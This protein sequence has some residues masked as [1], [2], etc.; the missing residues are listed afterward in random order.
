MACLIALGLWMIPALL[1]PEPPQLEAL[2]MREDEELTRELEENLLPA[3]EVT[4]NTTSSVMQVGHQTA[5]AAG[6]AEPAYDR[7]VEESIDGPKVE[8]GDVSIWSVKGRDLGVDVPRAI[9]RPLSTITT[10]LSTASR[11]KS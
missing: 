6:V 9:R 1:V 11:K 10:R 2:Q 5:M 3:T 4:L 8:V 7:A